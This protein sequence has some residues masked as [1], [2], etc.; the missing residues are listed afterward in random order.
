MLAGNIIVLIMISKHPEIKFYMARII[1]LVCVTIGIFA[2]LGKITWLNA[3]FSFA[4]FLSLWNFK[5][6]NHADG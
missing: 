6:K 3:I 2:Q 1:L 5:N 4:P